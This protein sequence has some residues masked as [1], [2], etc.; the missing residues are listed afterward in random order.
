MADT[1]TEFELALKFVRSVNLPHPDGQLL[2]CFLQDSIEPV[3]AARYIL[4]RCFVEREGLDL[5]SFVS[6]WKQLINMFA[7]EGS[8]YQLD[9]KTVIANIIK[10]DR[11]RCCITGL[12]NSFWDPLVV[13]PSLHE[14]LGAFVGSNLRDWYLSKAAFLNTYQNHWL[15]RKSAAAALWEGFFQVALGKELKYYVTVVSI[16]GPALPSIVDKTPV[17][18][19]DFFTNRSVSCVDN[20]DASAMQILSRF[21]KP[22]RW[23]LVAREIASKKPNTARDLPPAPL[24]HYFSRFNA[25]AVLMAWRLIPVSVRIRVYHGLT[26]LGAYMYGPSCSLNVQRFPFGMYVKIASVEHHNS[27]A[28]EYATLQ[29][30]RRYTDIPVPRALDLVSDLENSYLLTTRISGIRLGMCIDTLSDDEEAALVSDLQKTITALRAIPKVLAPEYAIT[31]ALGK[32]CF[33]YRINAGLDVHDGGDF[34]GPFVNEEEFNNTLHV[35][36]LPHISHGSRHQIVFTHR[37][38]NMRNILMRNGKLSGVVDWETS[39]WYP[40]YWDYTKAHYIT[41]LHQR[42]LKI[43]DNVFRHYGDFDTELSTERQLWWYCF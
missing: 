41:R 17:V 9:D 29:L 23:T 34:V 7:Y 25:A 38:L 4:Q 1:T 22:I 10:R 5:D 39:G 43:T 12:G 42:W 26:C 24:R 40:E 36:A 20:P 28:N 35:G 14:L 30:V 6:D 8:N 11:G 33:D 15:V 2:A 3:Q 13:A 37:D 16:G 19:N 31:N 21:A 32:A 18:R 27:L